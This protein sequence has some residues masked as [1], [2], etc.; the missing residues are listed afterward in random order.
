MITK[1]DKAIT[2]GVVPALS[3]IIFWALAQYAG[4]VLPDEVKAAVIT[5]LTALLVYLVPN[6][7]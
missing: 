6:K 5:V 7:Q 4:V 1:Y 2:A 3:V